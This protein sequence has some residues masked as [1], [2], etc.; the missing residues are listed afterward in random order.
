MSFRH[1]EV[2]AIT[3]AI[4]ALISGVDLNHVKSD[5]VYEEIKLALW[6]H[7]AVF[8]RKQSLYQK[9]LSASFG[10]KSWSSQMA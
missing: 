8:F 3:P 2:E 10:P 6:K 1:I 5:D 9:L 7:G 4:G